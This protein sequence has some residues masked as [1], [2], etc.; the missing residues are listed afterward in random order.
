MKGAF[1]VHEVSP[2]LVAQYPDHLSGPTFVVDVDNT[3]MFHAFRKGRAGDE[4]LH[5]LINSLF[6][7]QVDSD[8]PLKLKWVCSVDNKDADD[9]TRPGAVEHVRL[10][11]RCFGRLWEKWGGFRYGPDGD[12]SVRTMD[13]RCKP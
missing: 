5:D 3:T 1:A 8:F 4:R 11:Q 7:L 13:A 9:L 12:Q 6:W 10:K 2:L